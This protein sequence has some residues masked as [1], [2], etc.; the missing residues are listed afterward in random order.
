MAVLMIGHSDPPLSGKD[1]FSE[2]SWADII[3]ACQTNKVPDTWVIGDSKPMTINGVEY[4]VLVI[5]KKHDSYAD[6]TGL[7]PLTFQMFECY[8]TPYRMNGN[9]TN[10]G[11]WEYCQMR[12]SHI[13]TILSL[14]PGAV[15]SALREVSKLTTGGSRSSTIVTTADKLFLLSEMETYGVASNSTVAEGIQYEYYRKGYSTAKKVAGANSICWLR[16]PYKGNS[17]AFCCIDN[18]GGASYYN[19][20]NSAG[21]SLAFCF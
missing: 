14:M 6:G 4:K 15:Q 2:N 13:P 20:S 16:S 7:A 21:V 3:L 1:Y 11:G 17:N 19:S 12:T 10:A 9:D 8:T 5:G 18:G